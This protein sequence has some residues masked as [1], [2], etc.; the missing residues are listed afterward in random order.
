M[1]HCDGVNCMTGQVC[2]PTTGMCQTDNCTLGCP[3]GEQCAQS[4]GQCMPDPC[5]VVHCD[6]CYDCK[7]DFNGQGFC[8]QASTCSTP[9]LTAT[10]VGG[11]GCTCNVGGGG[12]G[13]ESSGLN[14]TALLLLIGALGAVLRRGRR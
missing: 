9:S 8:E 13:G 3:V 5:A 2:N 14:G 10:G 6:A 11:G 1:S 7:V 4:T 12:A